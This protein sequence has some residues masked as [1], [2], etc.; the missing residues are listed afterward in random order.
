[1]VS[2]DN[3]EMY[4]GGFV[5]S[6]IDDL[7]DQ[8]VNNTFT[9]P[10]I[11]GTNLS[12]NEAYYTGPNGTGTQY[13]PGDVV[14]FTDFATYPVTIYIY[15]GTAV[16]C[17]AEED[18]LL[19]IN[20]SCEFITT[21]RTTTPNEAIE[22]TTSNLWAYNY[23]INWGDGNTTLGATGT[24]AHVYNTPGDYQVTISGVFP[25]IVFGNNAANRVKLQSI[26]QWG[27]YA[28]QDL[29][30]AFN[31]CSNVAM[32]ALDI[33]N[34]T[35]VTSLRQ[36]FDNCD[37]LGASTGNWNWD[38]STITD[39]YG[40]FV[41]SD[42][43]NG[44]I[45]N[46][47]TSNV[48]DMERMFQ[49]ASEFNQDIGN[50]D[51]G[52][53]VNMATMFNGASIFNQDL[54]NWN[55]SN[56]T[57]MVGMFW[58]AISFNGAI[59]NWNTGSV[60]TMRLMFQEAAAFNQDIGNWDVS[61][62][63]NMQSMF[64]EAILFNQDIGN[65]DTGNVIDMVSMFRDAV[66]FDQDLG[67]W[68]VTSLADA[69]SMF[70]GVQLSIAN[71][72]SLLI[73]WNAQNLIP[74]VRFSGGL[75]QYCAGEAA[76]ANMVATD[77]WDMTDGG[78]AGPTINDLADQNATGSFTFPPI[79]G[80]N[81]TGNEA[82]YTEPNGTGTQYFAGDIVTFGDFAA[83]PV[84]IYIYDSPGP[85]CFSEE[86]FSLII[87]CVQ[88]TFYADT[89]NDGFGDPNSTIQDCS[90]PLGFVDNDDDCDDTNANVSPNAVEICDG[91]DNDCDGA[92]DEGFPDTD[93]NGIADCVDVEVCDGLDNDGDG[94]IDEG[95]TTTYYADTDNDGFGDVN[96]TIEACSAPSGYV[97]DA[98][99]CDDSNNTV[100]PGAPE[101]CDGLDN[102][103][104]GTIDEGVTI[105]F[106]ADTDSDGFG[107]A[108]NTI[109]ACSPPNG[110]VDNDDDCDDTNNTIYLNAPELC[111]GIDNDCDGTID[112][113]ATTTYYTD[114]DGDGFGDINATGVEACAPPN[115]TV[116]NNDDCDDANANVYPN[117]PELCDGIDNDCDG[118]IDEGVTTTYYTDADGDGFGDANSTGV[119][120]CS[121][122]NGTVDNNDDCDDTNANVYPDA[123]EL[124]DGLDND[125]D[126]LIE[127]PE[128]NPIQ[129]QEAINS[130]ILPTILGDNLSGNQA[131]YTGP[132]G[133]GTQYLPGDTINFEDFSTYPVTLYIYDSYDNGCSDEVQF[134]LTIIKTLDCAELVSPFNG[135]LNVFTDT[136]LSWDAVEDAT[137]YIVSIGT[138][139]TIFNI[140]ENQDVGNVLSYEPLENLPTSTTIY[141]SIV[142]YNDE[143][144]AENCFVYSF[145]TYRGELPP[146]FFTPNGDGNNDFW[147]VPDR[148]NRIEV[149]YIF[150][151]YGKLL[152]EINRIEL[153]WDGTYNGNLMPSNDYWYQITY[154]NGDNLSG[155]FSLKR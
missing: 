97:D 112:E 63:T 7:A 125:C 119:E 24:E 91:L 8:V 36:M 105:I 12:G 114:A 154:R 30:F 83:Y 46:W 35:N 138:S 71:Y 37:A 137:G 122:P 61:N 150:D 20:Q 149:I 108:N 28:W 133:T 56:V 27:C 49:G 69:L 81:L 15:D 107:D 88:S 52:N 132:N 47:D 145:V 3:W 148:F 84:T 62:V 40:L 115:G 44:D 59:G 29:D 70:S 113:G 121:P 100:Y 26:D 155:H 78:F 53:V 98:T 19:T 92:I 106:Y 48:T 116:D 16:G 25:K 126:G 102:D 65:W 94:A 4:D 33:P 31:G 11:T 58:Q 130:Y 144:I 64:N 23:D 129:N 147:I 79:T 111:D 131:F 104:D 80:T 67:N 127:E 75:S 136:I 139:A 41:Y 90:A 141:V 142:P 93:G 2:S 99:D 10:A 110:Y 34:L 66:S 21:W 134:N 146:P 18:F 5:G 95:L 57:N 151:R 73:G 43:F 50:W 6:V 9:F 38:T 120:A 143:Q 128:L 51:V 109:E 140:V 72:D 117:A 42:T 103:C 68:D 118:T 22:I 82:Y 39:M 14:N 76:R 32:N 60:T 101:I 1:M 86:D 13:L 85:G 152:K 123:P 96:N 74:N 135:E 17:E 77:F 54:N 87:A 153:G 45:S 55:T 124:C 89:D